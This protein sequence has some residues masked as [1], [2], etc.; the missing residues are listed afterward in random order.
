MGL[1]GAAGGGEGPTR[2]ST[3]PMWMLGGGGGAVRSCGG[4]GWNS[5]GGSIAGRARVGAKAVGGLGGGSGVTAG[6]ADPDGG[7]GRAADGGAA[8]AAS[9]RR[10]IGAA[11]AWL[12][13]ASP[14]GCSA[15]ADLASAD[16]GP[17]GRLET[18]AS[19]SGVWT[20]AGRGSGLGGGR[21]GARRGGAAP[22][23]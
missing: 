5:R 2:T 13:G 18:A 19:G 4:L 3:T 23:P 20:S 7:T 15:R 11:C 22:K 14:V 8:I 17:V 1:T 12:G 9:A 10:A 21:P 6:S 16:P